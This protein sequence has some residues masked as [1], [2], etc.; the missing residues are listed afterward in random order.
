MVAR[1]TAY[2]HRKADVSKKL[3]SQGEINKANGSLTLVP[4]GDFFGMLCQFL[5]GAADKIGLPCELPN[6][7]EQEETLHNHSDGPEREIMDGDFWQC[8]CP[9]TPYTP[10]M[11]PD[12]GGKCLRATPAFMN[13]NRCCVANV[14]FCCRLSSE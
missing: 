11:S 8:E 13:V 4:Y 12:A 3:I 1:R 10:A 9:D 6:V 2:S 7:Q 14:P 5:A